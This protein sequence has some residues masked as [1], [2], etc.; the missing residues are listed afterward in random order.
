MNRIKSVDSIKYLAIFCVIIIHTHPFQSSIE[1]NLPIFSLGIVLDQF[2]RFAVPF[3]FIISGYFW[4][5]GFD[6]L[7]LSTTIYEKSMLQIRRIA[8]I[9]FSWSI[10]YLLPYNFASIYQQGITG[11]LKQAYWALN[12]ALNNPLATLFQGTKEHLWYLMSLIS[13]ILISTIFIARYRLREA[14]Y[15][16]V[17]LYIFGVLAKAYSDTPIGINVEFNTRNGPFF[18]LPFFLT[19]HILART[20]INSTWTKGGVLFIILGYALHF[21][22]LHF[23]NKYYGTSPI[24]DYVF[25]TYFIGLGWAIL[26][27]SNTRLLTNPITNEL[28]KYTLG[29]YVIHHIFIINLNPIRYYYNFP[30][31]D[32]LFTL[33]ILTLSTISVLFLSKNRFFRRI[34][35]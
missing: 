20:K 15:L 23:L 26:A 5:N 28:G 35:I 7:K 16:S 29:I 11:P 24:Q 12:S 32:I 22:E 17:A 30:L 14:V 8:L 6:N 13:C 4:S 3:F 27:L 33:I 25:G 10:I 21:T 2:S 1:S 34:V 19:G 18:G 9:F 31:W